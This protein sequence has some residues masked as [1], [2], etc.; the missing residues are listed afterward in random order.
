MDLEDLENAR[1]DWQ[2]KL[3][4]TVTELEKYMNAGLTKDQKISLLRPKIIEIIYDAVF[5]ISNVIEEERVYKAF[6]GK[7]NGILNQIKELDES[8]FEDVKDAYHLAIRSHNLN[9]EI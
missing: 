5:M 3:I 8:L 7:E 9:T 1:E 6:L 2:R 4:E